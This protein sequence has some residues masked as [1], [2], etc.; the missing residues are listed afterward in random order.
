A[1]RLSF[2]LV[3][4]GVE[5]CAF[6]QCLEKAGRCHLSRLIVDPAKRGQGLGNLLTTQLV[7]AGSQAL[8]LDECA[9]YV[10]RSNHAALQCY[11]QLGF[12]EAPMIEEGRRFGPE[13]AYLVLDS[14]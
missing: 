10:L 1:A 9:L 13:V 5:L 11:Q 2:C 4:E 6:G 12:R 7:Q 14:K 3:N 8:G